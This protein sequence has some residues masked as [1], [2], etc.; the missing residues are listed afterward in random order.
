[1]SELK[2][3]G[4]L[5]SN[6]PLPSDRA[7][8]VPL[9]PDMLPVAAFGAFFKRQCEGLVNIVSAYKLRFE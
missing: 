9:L 1:M 4:K 3:A 8:G 2:T 6:W 7:N 5:R